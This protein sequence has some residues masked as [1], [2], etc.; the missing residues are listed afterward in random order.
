MELAI[1]IYLGVTDLY[2]R[3]IFFKFNT[4]SQEPR[5]KTFNHLCARKLAHGCFIYLYFILIK[6]INNFSQ[7]L[8]RL[9]IPRHRVSTEHQD[10]PHYMP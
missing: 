7:Q 3:F 10:V 4:K 9:S 2:A 6:V 1:I 5:H 8:I